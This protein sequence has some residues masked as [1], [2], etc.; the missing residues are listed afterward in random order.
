MLEMPDNTARRLRAVSSVCMKLGYGKIDSGNKRRLARA[1]LALAQMAEQLESG[2]PMSQR[3][4][5]YYEQELFDVLDVSAHIQVG[6]LLNRERSRFPTSAGWRDNTPTFHRLVDEAISAVR[7]DKGNLQIVDPAS[8]TLH[9]VASRGFDAPFLDF[10]ATV[11]EEDSSSCG[12]ALKR[13]HPVTVPNIDASPL[14][15]GQKSSEVFHQAGVRAVQS[16][17]II[18]HAGRFLGMVSTHWHSALA[19][20]EGSR[21]YLES[22]IRRAADEIERVITAGAISQTVHY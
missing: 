18:G 7:A 14:F 10:F 16:S 21:S 1:A 2:K 19:L 8:A 22:I 13:G 15:M 5:E 17:P 12:A 9:I 4:I 6:S 11:S 20:K 3:H